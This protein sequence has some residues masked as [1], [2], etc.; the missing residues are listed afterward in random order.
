M[1]SA[2]SEHCFH[3]PS[4]A[5]QRRYS[6][7]RLRFSI[8]TRIWDLG[9]ESWEQGDL[10]VGELG[11]QIWDQGVLGAE[12]QRLEPEEAACVWLSAWMV[13][14]CA[15]PPLILLCSFDCF[16]S[17]SFSCSVSP[18]SCPPARLPACL[19]SLS[20]RMLSTNCDPLL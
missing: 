8:R 17:P 20:T 5:S 7:S 14:D 18:S 1:Q 3:A 6:P 9:S 15:L 10:G 13:A 12:K 2:K 19:A 11:P 4:A 16:L